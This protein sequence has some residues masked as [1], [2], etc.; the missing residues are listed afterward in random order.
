M[1]RFLALATVAMLAAVGAASASADD[2]FTFGDAAVLGPVHAPLVPVGGKKPPRPAVL[3]VGSRRTFGAARSVGDRTPFFL[4]GKRRTPRKGRP[5][6]QRLIA[7]DLMNASAAQARHACNQREARPARVGGA[8]RFVELASDGVDTALG[9]FQPLRE[10]RHS[11]DQLHR[12][13]RARYL[14]SRQGPVEERLR[15]YRVSAIPCLLYLTRFREV[16]LTNLRPWFSLRDRGVNSL[17]PVAARTLPG[18][19]RRQLAFGRRGAAARQS[20][21]VS[22]WA[23]LLVTEDNRRQGKKSRLRSVL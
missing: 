23:A 21:P 1:K 22:S 17:T 3:S 9:L 14:R 11:I 4:L 13:Q 18:S 16:F 5:L 6:V 12:R 15:S 8:D 20:R 2:S 7:D 19:A 10:C